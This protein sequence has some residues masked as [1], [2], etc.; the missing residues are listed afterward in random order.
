M[1]LGNDINE[2]PVQSNIALPTFSS[3]ECLH[4]SPAVYVSNHQSFLD[5]YTLLSLG[6]SYKFI[7]NR[8]IFPI[9]G[10]AMSMMG[11]I[12]LKRMDSRSQLECLK[13]C[14]DLVRNGAS[15][16]FFPEGTRSKDRK[17]GDFKKGAFSVA[18]KTWVSVIPITLIG[19]GRIMP[20]GMEGVVNSG[21]VKV[22]IH[23][24]IEE[25]DPE[26]L[27]TESDPS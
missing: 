25:S 8:G 14:M 23:K 19:T 11:I 20:A 2:E 5:I 6:R 1:L 21:S 27:C 15:V 18:A 10:W 16:F 22:I 3:S 13:R 7:S 17:L 24:P 4:M 12:P 9:I 26:I